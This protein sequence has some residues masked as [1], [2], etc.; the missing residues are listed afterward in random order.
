VYWRI[1]VSTEKADGSRRRV[2]VVEIRLRDQ[3]AKESVGQQN[4]HMLACRVDA[5]GIPEK[6]HL[7]ARGVK[8]LDIVT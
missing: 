2:R 8:N 7:R 1:A 6:G 5:N 3:Q 4:Q